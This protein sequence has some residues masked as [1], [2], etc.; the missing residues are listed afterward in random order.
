[1]NIVTSEGP[2]ILDAFCAEPSSAKPTHDCSPVAYTK[3]KNHVAGALSG[4][5]WNDA[6]QFH[7]YRQLRT[8]LRAN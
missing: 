4:C 2:V 6:N 3:A 7:I 1:M 8:P 5:D